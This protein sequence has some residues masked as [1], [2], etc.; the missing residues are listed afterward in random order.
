MVLAD[1]PA[2]ADIAHRAGALL[3]VDNTLATPFLCRP[4]DHGADLVLHSAGKFLGGHGDVMA[5]VIAGSTKLIAAMRPVAYLTGPVLAPVEA[6]LT[7]RG[8]RT[9]GPRMAWAGETAAA[10]AAFLAQHPAVA[11]V[12]YPGQPPPD[13]A[14][15]TRTLLPSGAGCVLAFTLTGGP[16]AA[17]RF[18]AALQTIPYVPSIGG[19]TTI[20]SFPPRVPEFTPTGNRMG[21]PYQSEVV[22]LS[23]GLEDPAELLA[24]VEQA[25]IAA[26]TAIGPVTIDGTNTAHDATDSENPF[27]K[28]DNPPLP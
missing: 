23:I 1:I 24:D 10:I 3:I 9:L 12:Q 7:L 11:A 25:L 15:L 4:L 16:A 17:A 26:S 20:A 18:V 13:R 14:Q 5:G 2:L 28:A 22:R 27:P 19:T 6:W 8:M 21:E